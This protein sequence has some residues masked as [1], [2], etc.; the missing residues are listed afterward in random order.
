MMVPNTTVYL[1]FGIWR[2]FITKWFKELR[3]N[4]TISKLNKDV[5]IMFW[6][7]N[8]FIITIDLNELK[9]FFIRPIQQFIK[10][11]EGL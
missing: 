7:S 2:K 11:L 6:F 8:N 1:S 10:K 3:S 5:V 9:G 4:C